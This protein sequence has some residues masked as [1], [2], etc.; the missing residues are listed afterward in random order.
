MKGYQVNCQLS[1]Q[2]EIVWV[3]QRM[4][5]YLKAFLVTSWHQKFGFVLIRKQRAQEN[6]LIAL[7]WIHVVRMNRYIHIPLHKTI[8]EHFYL[9]LSF[10][11]LCCSTFLWASKVTSDHPSQGMKTQG[12]STEGHSL[13]WKI[14]A[15]VGCHN[16]RTCDLSLYN[17]IPF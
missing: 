13:G 6:S 4:C 16:Q 17:L 9:C 14:P 2:F 7:A 5:R 10:K 8:S 1:S 12:L 3:E 15:V 11:T